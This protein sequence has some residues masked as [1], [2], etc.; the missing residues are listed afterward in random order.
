LLEYVP[1]VK[2]LSGK[3]TVL[4]R[5]VPLMER[6]GNPQDRLK[7]VHIAGTSGKTST[8]YFMAALLKASG[9][10]VGLTVS[11]HVD[12]ITE[13]VQL[14]GLPISD[15]LFCAELTAFLEIVEQVEQ[16][17]SYFELLYAFSLWVFE[18]SGVDYAVIETG[19]G[20]LFDATNVVRRAD[21]V[22]I[23]TDIGYDHIHILGDTLAQIAGQKIGIAHTGNNV[24]TYQQQPEVM[25]VYRDWIAR[26]QAVLH[27]IDPTPSDTP[28]GLPDYQYRNWY[29]ACK[30]YEFLAGRDAL[31]DLTPTAVA[32]TQHTNVPARMDT[33]TIQNKTVIMDGAH[34][35]QKIQAF[36]ESYKR[37]YPDTKPVILVA[38]KSGKDYRATISTLAGITNE[39][40]VS[41]FNTTQ[42]L[43][44]VAATPKD[45]ADDFRH[46]GV[47]TVHEIPDPH[48]A[49]Q[50]L[51]TTEGAIKIVTGS[52]YL[53]SQIRK[54]V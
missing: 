30:T 5:I 13:R 16:K 18:R 9:S 7:V 23:I 26:Q 27:T 1:L 42:D 41:T 11:P 21:K 44:A 43:P 6:A 20:G 35:E 50:Y 39:I 49:F 24:F 10:S 19:M 51:L 33:K 54:N 45:I 4:D 8:A 46:A 14:N 34:N 36:T 40:I 3:D 47:D 15:A 22:C 12:T 53:I 37:L 2:Q 17:P 38:F 28:A 29:L 31:P 32:Q 25:G 48:E 52:F